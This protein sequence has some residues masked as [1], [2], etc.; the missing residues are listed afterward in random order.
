VS[1]GEEN[2]ARQ[3]A[4][5]SNCFEQTY[6]QFIKTVARGN[7]HQLMNYLKAEEDRTHEEVE[8]VLN[9]LKLRKI[10]R[11]LNENHAD[12]EKNHSKEEQEVLF[13]THEHL[14]NMEKGN[15]GKIGNSNIE[16]II[17]STQITY[18]YMKQ[19]YDL[20]P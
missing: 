14:K 2:I 8:S 3:L 6:E 11:M 17:C 10:K 9:Y 20:L 1:A 19:G 5:R 15:Y 16:M 18:H 4:I 12:L 13:R 7:D